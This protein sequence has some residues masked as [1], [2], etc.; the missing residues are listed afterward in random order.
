[1]APPG[2][3]CSRRVD[4]RA[5]DEGPHSSTNGGQQILPRR[6]DRSTSC[7]GSKCLGIKLYLARSITDSGTGPGRQ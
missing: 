6:F 7:L 5:Q 3:V 1:M 4:S 2:D